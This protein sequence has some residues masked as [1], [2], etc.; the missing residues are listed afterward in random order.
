MNE[1]KF[2]WLAIKVLSGNHTPEEEYLL[3]QLVKEDEKYSRLYEKLRRYWRTEL[4]AVNNPVNVEQALQATWNKIKRPGEAVSPVTPRG[5]R[6]FPYRRLMAAATILMC[7]LAGWWYLVYRHQ[8][9]VMVE[10]YNQKGTRSNIILADGSRIWL[11]ADS[12]LRYPAAFAPDRRDV[13]LEGEAFF[14]IAQRPERPFVVHLANGTVQVLG[15]SFDIKAYADEDN[16]VTSVAT[17]KVAFIPLTG[18]SSSAD[19]VLLTP[20]KKATLH[21]TSGQVELSAT[22]AEADRAWING[23]LIFKS[24]T[25]EEI[26][27]QLDRYY[28]KPVRFTDESVRSFHYTGSF[29]NNTQE[30]IL[31]ILSKTRPFQYTVSDSL[32]VIGQNE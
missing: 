28:G 23:E 8:P 19:T 11:N 13:Y 31:Q 29:K 24:Q 14:E 26:A 27:R 7:L 15:T 17:G 21:I 10:K 6:R 9:P 32:I 5:V 3:H 25:L 12:R 20:D 22:N 30:E 2:L 18:F 16:L 1:E 4:D